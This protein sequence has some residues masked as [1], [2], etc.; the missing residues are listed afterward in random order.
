MRHEA[1]EAGPTTYLG[2]SI[3]LGLACAS[4]PWTR[5]KPVDRATDEFVHEF[6][7]SH[8]I[9]LKGFG[10]QAYRVPTQCITPD[11]AERIAQKT[12]Q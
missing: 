11:K 2:G 3:D 9:K 12:L 8:W 6:A 7:E 5:F 1:T 10:F 4:E